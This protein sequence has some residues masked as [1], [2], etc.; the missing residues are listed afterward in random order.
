MHIPVMLNEVL[1]NLDISPKGIYFDCTF[2]TGGHSSSIARY[3]NKYS[4]LNLIDK[5]LYNFINFGKRLFFLKN[6]VVFY[7][8]SFNKILSIINNT[9][10]VGRVDGVLIDLG[11]SNFQLLDSNRGFGF[12]SNGFLDMR[13]NLFQDIRAVDWFNF[14]S[15]DELLIVFSFINNFKFANDIVEGIL[16][17]RKKSRIITSNDFYNILL[18]ICNSNRK[19]LKFFNKIYQSVRYFINNDMFCLFLFLDNIFSALRSSGILL[20]ISFNSLED[21]I[22]KI[23]FKNNRY[24]LNS[25]VTFIKPSIEELNNNYSSR[26]AVMRVFIKK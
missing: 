16:L 22:I 6:K 2:G 5:D 17:F 3:L 18:K 12:N 23:F 21:S 24:V 7:K 25:F 9:G 19:Y 26:S 8:C 4:F 11:I 10:L 13:L 1:K 20:F 14:A 15:Y